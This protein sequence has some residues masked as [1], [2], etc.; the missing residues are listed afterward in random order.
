MR[1][2]K[3]LIVASLPIMS[4]D[5][6]ERV[7]HIRDADLIE[8]RLDYLRNPLSI[9]PR[10]LA[11]YRDRIIIT[12]RETSEGGVNSVDGRRKAEYL[13]RLYELGVLYDVEASFI[14][15]YSVPYKGKIVSAHYMDQM[16]PLEHLEALVNRYAREA[17]ILKIAL[18][19]SRGYRGVLARLLDMG[20]DNI[21]VMPLG[22]DP[23]VSMD[24]IA[25]SL[26]G[27]R[28]L[29]GYVDK[30][31]APGQMHYREAIDIINCIMGKSYK[32]LGTEVFKYSYY[33]FCS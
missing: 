6:L 4:V 33:N 10:D 20:Y 31:T 25:L 19:A 22:S 26:M 23:S 29:Y 18:I 28:L 1:V 24:R 16:P 2:K 21:A 11:Q 9:D 15:K 14:E 32:S 3:P 13:E 30:P 27:S 17:L 12:I 5:D 8:L 7:K